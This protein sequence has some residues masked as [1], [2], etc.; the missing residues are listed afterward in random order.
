MQLSLLAILFIVLNEEEE[1][2]KKAKEE[3]NYIFN[4]STQK[5]KIIKR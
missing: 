3:K 4:N 1:T 2:I 5:N